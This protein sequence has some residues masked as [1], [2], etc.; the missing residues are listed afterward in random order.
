M[1]NKKL[2][3]FSRD[4]LDR[5]GKVVWTVCKFPEGLEPAEQPGGSDNPGGMG[6]QPGTKKRKTTS[7]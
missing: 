4:V 3:V 6:V 5:D 2:H 7:A 1:E